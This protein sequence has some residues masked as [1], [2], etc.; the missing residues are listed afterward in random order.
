MYQIFDEFDELP[1]ASANTLER[2]TCIR[3]I[4]RILNRT[5]EFKE[6]RQYYP[7]SNGWEDFSKV[8]CDDDIRDD[9]EIDF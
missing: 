8:Q 9:D 3:S 4:Y 6:R 5:T 2:A 7:A 1:V